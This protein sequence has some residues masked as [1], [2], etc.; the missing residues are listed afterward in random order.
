[1][2]DKAGEWRTRHTVLSI[3]FTL[4]AFGLL[5]EPRQQEWR[6][7]DNWHP[8]HAVI[9]CDARDQGCEPATGSCANKYRFIYERETVLLRGERVVEWAPGHNALCCDASAIQCSSSRDNA[10]CTYK[11]MC[12]GLPEDL[13]AHV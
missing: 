10:R 11:Y 12:V 2:A 9:C 4:L 1:M 5:C 8:D 6:T 3:A 13:Y 7:P